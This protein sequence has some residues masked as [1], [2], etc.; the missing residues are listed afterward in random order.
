MPE[1]ILINVGLGETR[2][3]VLRD[4]RLAE[5]FIERVQNESPMGAIYLGRVQRVV[6]GMEAA[7]VDIGLAK[8][9]FLSAWDARPPGWVDPAGERKAPAIATLLQ[10]GQAVVVQAVKE[11]TG[12]KGARL[13]TQVSLPGRYAVLM[14][15]G[16]DVALSRRIEDEAERKRLADIVARSPGGGVI[17]RT[18]A[19]GAAERDLLADIAALRAHWTEIEERARSDD[20][21]ACLHQELSP[22]ERAVRDLMRADTARV[23]IDD[24]EQASAAR[25]YATRHA[26]AASAAI[27]HHR[28]ADLF[29]EFGVEGQV[30]QLYDPEVALPSGGR[31]TIEHTE[32]LTSID[33][34]SGRYVRG[35]GQA[36]TALAINLEAAAEVARQL[37]LRNVG[38]IVVIDF[39]HMAE[40][41]RTKVMEALRAAVVADRAPVRIG[42]LSEFGLVE[43]TRKRTRASLEGAT[44]DECPYCEGRRRLASIDTVAFEALRRAERAGREHLGRSDMLVIRA[45][46]EVAD[47][48]VEQGEE[49]LRALER[50]VGRSVE[51]DGDGD[52][53]RDRIEIEHG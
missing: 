52:F 45:A 7:F 22:V 38:G 3:A 2:V 14:P 19:F 4:G 9:G 28:G 46:P 51:I 30:A 10:E 18:A 42:Q 50:R 20:A 48:L 34:N 11:P 6:P 25:Q 16:S 40:G 33:V 43:M 15:H 26:P 17:V 12:D 24:G 23:V 53:A 31:I 21:P 5:L 13:S 47:F 36:E 49:L 37:R 39:I 1:D 41:D 35:S 29:G 8:D 32:A 27:E 44:T